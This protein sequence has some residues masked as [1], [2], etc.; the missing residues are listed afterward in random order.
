M[1]IVG[2]GG[3]GLIT[4]LQIIGQ[5][6]LIEG[7]EVRTSELHGLSQRGGSVEVH[8]RFG[9]NIFS[10]LVLPGGADLILGLEAGEVLGALTYGNPKTKFLVN[11]LILPIPGTEIAEEK[12]LKLLKKSIKNLTLIEATKICEEKLKNPVVA[13]VYLLSFA[14]FKKFLPLSPQSVQ[15]AIKKVIPEKY[16]ELNLKAFNLAK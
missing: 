7:W 8:A 6:A 10:P 11:K 3:Q 5:A 9:E 13:G 12:I 4:L 15:K 1:V 16:L 2:T 14:S